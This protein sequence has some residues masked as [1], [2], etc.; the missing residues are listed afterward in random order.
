MFGLIIAPVDLV[1][2][3]P[4]V[5]ALA[6]D[7]ATA[8]F[9]S[10]EFSPTDSANPPTPS[11]RPSISPP[12][13]RTFSKNKF[14]AASCAGLIELSPQL[15]EFVSPILPGVGKK[16]LPNILDVYPALSPIPRV[17]VPSVLLLL[18]IGL[19]LYSKTEI[20]NLS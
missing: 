10:P 6:K 7:A 17:L 8:S 5:A 1:S 14:E 19:G 3:S 13:F 18:F 2:M 15:T 4:P 9:T 20:N 11:I 12:P 16:T